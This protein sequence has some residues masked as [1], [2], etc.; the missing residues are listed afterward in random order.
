MKLIG[1][2]TSLRSPEFHERKERQRKIRLTITTIVLLIVV[3]G[4]ILL[5]R[6]KYILISNIQIVGNEVTPSADIES[7]V[8][9]DLAGDYLLVI[10]KS[11][12]IFY[13]K[14][15]IK[16]D[17]L[18]DIPRL[19]VADVSLSNPHSLTV[20]VRERTPSALYCTDVTNIQNPSDCYFLD[21]S[22]Y[23]FSSAPAFSGGVYMVYSS[24]P[25]LDTPL[26]TQF[27]SSASFSELANFIGTLAHIPLS[28]KVFV[29]KTDEDDLLL[30][31]GTVVMWKPEQNLD[32]VYTNLNAF[33]T[34]PSLNK[35]T[36]PNLL[37]IDLRF[38]DKVFYKF[39]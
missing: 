39:K 21:A 4:P 23:I 14:N 22:G 38:D 26:R 3:V 10:P 25:A 6:N 33:L 37:Y 31:S 16:N 15:K 24:D 5:L 18:N 32:A 30:P 17:I 29:L 11:S 12:A 28:P 20:A 27:M 2:K 35:S 13:P 1:N 19:S 8:A 7:I 36:V 34:D 9:N